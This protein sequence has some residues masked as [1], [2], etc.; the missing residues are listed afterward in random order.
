EV[1]LFDET[2]VGGAGVPIGRGGGAKMECPD[3]LRQAEVAARGD[4]LLSARDGIDGV[5]LTRSR[6]VA[7]RADIDRAVRGQLDAVQAGVDAERGDQGL[8]ARLRIDPY[9]APQI[10]RR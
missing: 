6:P 1:D 3:A 10:I 5:D 7:N 8:D 9:H 2:L 4:G